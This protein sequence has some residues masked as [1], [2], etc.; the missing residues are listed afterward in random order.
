MAGAGITG[1]FDDYQCAAAAP[2][3][4]FVDAS[5]AAGGNGSRAAPVRTIAAALADASASTLCVAAGTYVEN[6][7]LSNRAVA[8]VGGFNGGFTQRDPALQ[9][10]VVKPAAAGTAT[11][12]ADGFAQLTLDGLDLTG[13]GCT[14]LAVHTWT[15]GTTVRLLNTRVHHNVNAGGACAYSQGG[16]DISGSPT[17]NVEIGHSVIE[18]NDGG[19]FGGGGSVNVFDG[20]NPVAR[21]A[22]ND[23]FGQLTGIGAGG[24][25]VHHSI[26]R[27]NR[28]VN[29]GSPHGAGLALWA[30]AVVEHNEFTGNDT[31]AGGNAGDGVG[32]GLILIYDDAAHN[33]ATARVEGNWFEANRAGNHGAA[34]MLD[35]M[36]A[37]LVTDNVFVRNKGS[38][39]LLL[40][41][42]CNSASCGDDTRVF[43]T[44]VNNTVALNEGAGLQVQNGTAHLYYNVF[45][46]N[47]PAPSG[48]VV[49]N[50]IATLPDN[51]VRGD[52][53]VIHL[54]GAAPAQLTG[55]VDMEA[56]ADLLAGTAGY[57]LGA[58][59]G[60]L[61]AA[62]ASFTPAFAVGAFATTVPGGG[63]AAQVYGLTSSPATDFA[64]AARVQRLLGAYAT[65]AP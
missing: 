40:D 19:N 36:F 57:R 16:F 44:V 35:G 3:R 13:A 60:A 49:L 41:S 62:S 4:K 18:S 10:T 21:G 39:A 55:S 29:A 33:A 53:N 23:G 27:G 48:D 43:M 42:G 32:G 17:M 51:R 7:D 5:A 24:I 38:G 14:A 54:V 45:W 37:A 15:T 26:V 34:L 52:R 12:N 63:T 30:N 8:V 22:A 25:W 20:G 46:R 64:G 56:A 1:P 59:Y 11:L 47:A 6:L 2:G 31:W 65:T 9:P 61:T 58:A 28:V 50:P